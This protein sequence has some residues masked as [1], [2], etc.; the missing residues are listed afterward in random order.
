M[1]QSAECP[2][3]MP[4]LDQ[5]VCSCYESTF[6]KYRFNSADVLEVDW[7]DLLYAVCIKKLSQVTIPVLVMLQEIENSPSSAATPYY[8]SNLSNFQPFP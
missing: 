4:Q 1:E 2:C 8:H 5:S 3:G 6:A 7:S